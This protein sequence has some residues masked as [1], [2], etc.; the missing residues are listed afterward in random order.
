M[1]KHLRNLLFVSAHQQMPGSRLGRG[2][3]PCTLRKTGPFY[4]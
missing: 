1:T 4:I 2:S 3:Y